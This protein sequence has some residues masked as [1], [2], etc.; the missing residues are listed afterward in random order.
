MMDIINFKNAE[1]KTPF[2][3]AYDYYICE[4]NVGHLVDCKKLKE[5]ILYKEKEILEKFDYDH[6]WNTGLGKNSLTSRSNSYN[7]LKWSG[8]ENLKIAIKENLYTFLKGLNLPIDSSYYV[9]CWANVLRTGEFI[10]LHHHWHSPYTFLG[11]HVCVSS[12]ETNT[13]Y[14]NPYTYEEYQSNNTQGKL[15]LFPNW[16]PHKTTTNLSNDERVTIAFDIINEVTYIEDIFDNK[17]EHWIKL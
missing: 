6:D 8:T 7:L 5:Q 10:K 11:G 2:A 1:K 3:P 13:I 12:C 9:Q 16:L 4:T 17:K 14:V 15:T